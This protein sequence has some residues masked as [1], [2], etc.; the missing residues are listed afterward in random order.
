MCIIY[1]KIQ[2]DTSLN[3]R[4]HEVLS[5]SVSAQ[6]IRIWGPAELDPDINK[7]LVNPKAGPKV[8]PEFF[9]SSPTRTWQNRCE[10]FCEHGP[11]RTCS[12]IFLRRL[13]FIHVHLHLF[14]SSGVEGSILGHFIPKLHKTVPGNSCASRSDKQKT[15]RR[16]HLSHALVMSGVITINCKN[17]FRSQLKWMCRKQYVL[18]MCGFGQKWP[19]QTL[20]VPRQL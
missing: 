6:V 14:D 9:I 17:L 12:A 7:V 10:Q 20:T 3:R 13:K 2:A 15:K 19:D 11:R 5:V 8:D 1:C 4:S 16:R 18:N